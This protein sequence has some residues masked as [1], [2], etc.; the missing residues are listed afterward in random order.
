VVDLEKNA[1]II[2]GNDEIILQDKNGI[3]TVMDDFAKMKLRKN[4]C[5]KI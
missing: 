4:G 5:R 2:H 1:I 3:E